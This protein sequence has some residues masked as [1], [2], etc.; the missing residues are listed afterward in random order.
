[1]ASSTSDNV[2]PAPQQQ[3]SDE[4]GGLPANI[5]ENVKMCY[6]SFGLGVY[7]VGIRFLTMPLEKTAMVMNSSQVRIGRLYLLLSN[8]QI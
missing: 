3:R 7:A 2:A 6:R 4:N 5:A 8:T 1:M